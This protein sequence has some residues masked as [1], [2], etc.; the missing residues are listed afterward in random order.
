MLAHEVLVEGSSSSATVR[1]A[2]DEVH[3]I[4]KASGKATDTQGHVNAPSV[5][6]ANGITSTR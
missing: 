3:Q 1:R 5:S 4:R 6:S 2:I